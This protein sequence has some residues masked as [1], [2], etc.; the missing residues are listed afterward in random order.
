ML[1]TLSLA[2]IIF[3]NVSGGAFSLEGLVAAVGPGMS[4]L[5]LVAAFLV[6]VV[7]YPRIG[8]VLDDLTPP[9]LPALSATAKTEAARAVVLRPRYSSMLEKIGAR[10]PARASTRVCRQRAIRPLPSENG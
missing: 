6:L 5:L 3:F 10:T 7:Q 4:L 2:A 8:L 9:R 1:G